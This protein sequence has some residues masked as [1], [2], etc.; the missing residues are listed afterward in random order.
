M[1]IGFDAKR[2]FNNKTGLGNYSRTLVWNLSKNYPEHEYF[3]Y[4]PSIIKSKQTEK[5]IDNPAFSIR[6]SDSFLKS[7][8]RS[9]GIIDQ[10]KKDE[11]DVFHGLSHE[12]PIGIQKTSIKSIVTIHDMIFKV[13]P[14]TFPLID[15]KIY[16]FKFRYSCNNANTVIAISESTKKDIEKY[17]QI[18]PS[19][20][21]VVYQSCHPIYYE[22]QDYSLVEKTIQKH[23]L[24]DNF[25]LSV[26]SIEP[27]KNLKNTINALHLLN[28]KNRLPLVVVGRGKK[29][30]EDC[31]NLSK[32]LGL[33]NSIYW[34]DRLDSIEELKCIYHKA[35]ALI[36]PSLYEGFGLPVVEALLSET[37]V[38][39]SNCS[40][41]PE[42]GGPHSIYIDPNNV[43]EIANA[44][45]DVVLG[46]V[47]IEEMKKV[48]RE[49]A[50]RLRSVPN[51]DY[52]Q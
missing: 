46:N 48:G 52:T 33:E 20:I 42:A 45:S 17:Y 18:D 51:F 6:T 44:I 30:K 13:L 39:T 26:G 10:L 15:R 21:K 3:L 5:F 12:I 2:L 37:P 19:K 50:L 1:K 32:K 24:P 22:P 25:L 8:W 14:E 27:R 29:Y 31:Q 4:T 7:Y 28:K 34:I 23:N 11:L 40:S 36:Y 41:L 38:I 16:D 43:E 35:K 9:Y 49:Y 47:D